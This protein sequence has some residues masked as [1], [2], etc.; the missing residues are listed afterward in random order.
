[1]RVTLAGQGSNTLSDS[2]SLSLS[3]SRARTHAVHARSLGILSRSRKRIIVIYTYFS[4]NKP[5]SCRSTCT[6]RNATPHHTS[7]GCG[8]KMSFIAYW[9]CGQSS[10]PHYVEMWCLAHA[11]NSFQTPVS[12]LSLSL[13]LCQ[14]SYLDG[15]VI[16][17]PEKRYLY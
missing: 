7:P 8:P 1:V 17:D 9:I 11:Q 15:L 13:S 14:P 16:Y 2:L 10:Q 3:L 12:A 5:P 6:S 4:Y